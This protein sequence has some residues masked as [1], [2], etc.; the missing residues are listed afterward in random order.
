MASSGSLKDSYDVI[1]VGGG[2][3]GSACATYL[4]KQGRDVL[5]LDRAKFPRDKV[6]GDG[7]SGKSVQILKELGA[8]EAVQAAEHQDMYGV[9]FSSPNGMVV[10]I[11]SAD[12]SKQKAPGFVCRREV[13]DNVLFQHAKKFC[14]VIEGFFV[15]DLIRESDQ[16]VGVTGMDSSTRQNHTFRSKLV[17]GADGAGSIVAR[18]VGSVNNDEKHQVAAI[19][20]YYKNVEGNSDQ[21]ELHFVP[22]VIPG[23]FW[24]FPL[25][26][27]HANVGI[28]ML[29]SHMKQKRVNLQQA[30][31]DAIQNNALFKERFANAQ[32][33][34]GIKSW[35]LPLG[36]KRVKVAGNGWMLIGD[37]A[38]LIDPFSGEGIGNSLV[39]AK[40]ASGII[41]VAFQKND[42]TEATLGAFQKALF[43]ELGHSL[44]TSYKLQK[45]GQNTFLLNW[46]IGKAARKEKVRQAISAALI[47]PEQQKQFYSPWFYLK[48]LFA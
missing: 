3:A 37:A 6:C 1:V 12:K 29:V 28:G 35:F 24:I 39:S 11:A 19:R 22:E 10:P 43:D 26:N 4:A 14:T 15:N 8:L 16:V 40:V 9:T 42:F 5:L 45:I 18:K 44:D 17:V 34:G 46:I 21:I 33:E 25:P 48:L 47:N 20:A 2:P 27:K 13:F 32:V 31:F 36:S 41:A 7:T 30:M 38:S 23:Y